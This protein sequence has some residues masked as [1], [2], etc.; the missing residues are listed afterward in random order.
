[1][2]ANAK[3]GITLALLVPCYNAESYLEEFISN[4]RKLTEPFDE[5]IFY[6]DGSSDTTCE[7]L[8][9]HKVNHIASKLNNGPGYARNRLAEAST[10]QYIH[11]HDVDDI[12][13]KDYVSI[14]KQN[15]IKENADVI[16]GNADWIDKMSKKT[17]IKWEYNLDELQKDALA[18]FLT[19]PLGIINTVYRKTSFML[20]QG[21]DQTQR[22]WEDADLNIRLSAE[23]IK[24]SVINMT[25]AYSIRHDLG[26]SKNQSKCWNCR[27]IFLINYYHN[28]HSKYHQIIISEISKCAWNLFVLG[29]K[30]GL[31]KAI[32]SAQTFGIYLPINKN[33]ILKFLKIFKIRGIILFRIHKLTLKGLSHLKFNN[34]K[35]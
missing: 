13:I 7:V 16:L 21:F 23:H 27:I 33:P 31:S 5:V 30:Q 15:I 11:F 29:D 34:G 18:Y 6:D 2:I 8:L 19:H 9:K 28:L 25:V 24:F 22:C 1:M 10:C 14:F 17:I 12:L 3:N 26:I 32:N 20:V 4:L 35:V